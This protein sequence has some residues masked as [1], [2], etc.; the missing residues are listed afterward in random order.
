MEA[1]CPACRVK[2][3]LKPEH[4]GKNIR[5]PKC[6]TVFQVPF[7]ESSG[8]SCSKCGAVLAEDAVICVQCGYN[9]KTGQ[10]LQTTMEDAPP[11]PEGE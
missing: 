5:C 1:S 8:S 4:A 9:L 6:E 3:K 10:Q 2:L 11:E 7:S